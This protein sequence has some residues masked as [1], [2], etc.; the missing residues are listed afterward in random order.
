M[1]RKEQRAEAES[2]TTALPPCRHFL[3]WLRATQAVVTHL[4]MLHYRPSALRP[5]P[6]LALERAIARLHAPLTA[7]RRMLAMLTHEQA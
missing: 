7:A 6:P 2:V 1:L 5:R 4:P 3:P